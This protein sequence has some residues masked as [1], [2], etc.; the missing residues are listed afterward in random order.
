MH[1]IVVQEGRIRRSAVLCRLP[2]EQ[3]RSEGVVAGALVHRN[4]GR[5]DMTFTSA[6]ARLTAAAT[7]ALAVGGGCLS[8]ILPALADVDDGDQV[9]IRTGFEIAPV[10]L[11]LE[12]KDPRLVGLGSY[13]V[14]AVDHCNV[15]HS[16]GPASEYAQGGNPYFK[17]NQPTVVNQATYLGGGRV[18]PPFVS[19]SPGAT[20]TIVSRNLTPDRTGRP[21]GGRTFAE[22]REIM[23]TGLDLDHLHPNCSDPTI[24]A[25]TSCFPLNLPWDGDRL[26]IMPW[27]ELRHLT[28]H[29]L[30]A[31]YEYLRAIPCNPGPPTGVN[32]NEC[33]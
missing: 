5:S 4:T 23:R 10:P 15:C 31:V 11:N 2:R 22:F 30:R 29:E 8:G 25:S 20:P 19:G 7:F 14:N 24:T 12:G 16:A 17:G 33:T 28:E 9:Q 27:P 21:E 1:G 3:V 18:F 13:I 6:R 32:H 26:Q